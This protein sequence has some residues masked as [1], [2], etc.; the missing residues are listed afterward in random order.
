MS[1]LNFE[2]S[3]DAE[4]QLA[5]GSRGAEQKAAARGRNGAQMLLL[6]RKRLLRQHLNLQNRKTEATR[7]KDLAVLANLD[8]FIGE[9][10]S[11]AEQGA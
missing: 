3:A 2:T 6:N 4:A 5:L 8:Q 9:E 11:R 7:G 10:S 1:E